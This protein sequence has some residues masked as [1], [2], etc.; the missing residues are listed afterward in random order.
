MLIWNSFWG[1]LCYLNSQRVGLLLDVGFVGALLRATF[2]VSFRTLVC[3]AIWMGTFLSSL[4][5]V[6]WLPSP[7]HLIWLVFLTWDSVPW[8]QIHPGEVLLCFSPAMLCPSCLT[9]SGTRLGFLQG[10]RRF[11]FSIPLP[12]ITELRP[13]LP[14]APQTCD[15]VHI[16]ESR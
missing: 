6:L 1:C 2:P 13:S 3:R 5:L 10:K 4:S 16:S 7:I 12:S 9:L 14:G 11:Q 8:W 15:K